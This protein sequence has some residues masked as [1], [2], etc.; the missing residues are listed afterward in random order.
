MDN[1]LKAIDI[2]R[3]IYSGNG[4]FISFEP[5]VCGFMNSDG[6]VELIDPVN[7][8]IWE[9]PL[10]LYYITKNTIIM[11]DR[12][13]TKNY[14]KSFVINRHTFKTIFTLDSELVIVEDIMYEGIKS[15]NNYMNGIYHTFYDLDGYKIGEVWTD[16]ARIRVMNIFNNVYMVTGDNT[17]DGDAETDG[18]TS[19]YY[20]NKQSNKLEPLIEY[21]NKHYYENIA[22]GKFVRYNKRDYRDCSVVDL[23]SMIKN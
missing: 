4:K 18:T 17:L 13:L 11:N 16:T 23:S 20:Y 2:A 19:F 22:D 10:N 21:D 8:D 12:Q 9:K 5:D 6:K 3:V 7:G 1:K 14:M 15:L